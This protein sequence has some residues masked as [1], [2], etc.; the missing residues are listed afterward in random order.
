LSVQ[1]NAQHLFEY[2]AEVYAIDLPVV[3]DV[4][5][6]SNERWW[7]GSLIP[8]DNCRFRT[9]DYPASCA[10]SEDQ[11]GAW[12]SIT[13]CY[14]DP[15]PSLP[16]SLLHWVDLSP[17]P[18]ITPEPKVVRTKQ[19]RF[20][21]DTVRVASYEAYCDA[22]NKWNDQKEG[23][24]PLPETNLKSW[25]DTSCPKDSP[26]RPI[27]TREIE[28]RFDKDASRPEAF[29]N[30]LNDQWSLWSNRKKGP[31]R[32]N[33]LYDE[34]FS[35]HQRLSV[36]GDR[37]EILWGHL[38]LSWQHSPGHHIY[39]P[40]LLTPLFIDFDAQNRTITLTPSQT[41]RL[42]FECL[43]DLEYNFK[44]TL[45][46]LLRKI[47]EDEEP[48]N[49]WNHNTV[50][51]LAS[52]ISGY[53]SNRPQSE[54]N[55]YGDDA[56]IGPA[57]SNNHPSFSNSPIIFVRERVRHFWI[58]DAKNVAAAIASGTSVPPFIHAAVYNPDRDAPAQFAWADTNDPGQVRK[59]ESDD[60]L[61][62]PLHH[63]E[64]QKEIWD[65]L[66]SQFGVL[67]QGPPGTGKSHTIANI[68]CDYLARGK[69]IL[70]TSQTENSL[71]VL[72][73]HIPDGI[74]SLC[75][76]QLGNDTSAKT[77]LHEAVTTIGQHLS[78]KGSNAPAK[79]IESL[80]AALKQ[81]RRDQAQTASAIRE[82][83]KLDIETITIGGETITAYE[84]A[85]EVA[86][87]SKVSDWLPDKV[88]PTDEPPL[89]QTELS[90]LCTLAHTTAHQ[91]RKA[92][93]KKLPDLEKLPSPESIGD[94]LS[95][96]KT[97][98]SLAAETEFQRA[99]WT[100]QLFSA[101]E[102]QIAVAI[103][104]V[105]LA[106]KT[107]SA[108]QEKWQ[109]RMLELI[110]QE[111][112]QLLFWSNFIEAC[113]E[114]RHSAFKFFDRIQG[115]QIEGLATLDKAVEWIPAIDQLAKAVQKGK[116]PAGFFT[117][118]TLSKEAKLLYQSVSIDNKPLSTIER[119]D[120]ATD[121]LE[122]TESLERLEKRWE[123]SI[124]NIDGPQKNPTALMPLAD[125]DARLRLS[126]NPIEWYTSHYNKIRDTL[127]A[128]GCPTPGHNFHQEAVLTLHLH[129]LIGHKAF[130]D[131]NSITAELSSIV[132]TITRLS[133]NSNCHEQMTQL[134]D[135]IQCRS[136]SAYEQG[137]R[138]LERLHAVSSTV[139]SLEKLIGRLRSKA[140]LWCAQIEESA[141]KRGQDAIPVDWE[142]AWKCQ[143]LNQWLDKLHQRKNIS[144]LQTDAEKLRRRESE[145]LKELVIERTWQRQIE[146]VN[147]KHYTALA[148]WAQAMKNYGRG[149][150]PH[151][152][153]FLAAATK[154][155]IDAVK[156]VPVWI[157]PLYR[158]V[159]AF[160][161]QAGLFDLIIVDEASQCDIRAL[162]V[163]FRAKQVL[164]VGD[165]EQISPSNVGVPR[166]KIFEL[167]RLRLAEIPHP[168]RF[169]VDNS[170]F[171]VTQTIP[172]MTR[173]MLT[174]HFRCVSEIIEF[175]N[176]LCP[177]YGGQLEPLRQTNPHDRLVPPVVSYYVSDG[178]KSESDV[179]EAEAIALVE[180][181]K[182]CCSCDRY[183][184]K[185]MGIISLLGEQQAK[186][187]SNLLSKTI[188]EVERSKRRIVCGNAYAFQGDERDVMFLSLVVAR[189]ARFAALVKDDARQRF[190][191]ATSRARDQVFLFHSVS[192]EDIN[193]DNC[194]RHKLLKW[195]Q[196][197][198]L[199]EM[200]ANISTLREKAE[201][202]F[203]LEVGSL[204]IRNGFKVIPQY[205]PFLRDTSYRIDLLAQG[206][207]GKVAVECDGDRWHGPEQW[208]YD[209]K[210]EAQL[211]RAGL[212]FWRINGSTFYRNKDK[213][214]SE[215]WPILHRH[216]NGEG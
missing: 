96:L 152:Q 160:P 100:V 185:T 125:V 70:V 127:L 200:E 15:P 123:Q 150:G 94:L 79:R 33:Q 215:L 114:L 162:P 184:A 82:W 71:R 22:W 137:F 102:H 111:E 151:A 44:E 216:C 188:D 30:Y 47:N 155:M 91:D 49:P 201:S 146:K 183:S 205:R 165:P 88:N 53:L 46:S 202:P 16:E 64:Q 148:A 34:L 173:T 13:K 89:N 113:T 93:E 128:L 12:L 95:R 174:E 3:R 204:I 77:E 144:D 124:R 69:K 87:L 118:L 161:A 106:Q 119:I 39:H 75:V 176:T 90:E 108:M 84:A 76:S 180:A 29:K 196:N 85:Q 186:F 67:V 156:A 206:P 129:S 62:F 61:Y 60:E 6:Y 105:E 177:S 42:D 117:N 37:W 193:N 68:I 115:H 36:E 7:Q 107:L 179:N 72:R 97:A 158:V 142:L 63:N 56:T 48:P 181:V 104:T 134:C 40:L 194:M 59:A 138:E 133:E 198:P 110:A 4:L 86:L 98:Q 145:L 5:H 135:A 58:E 17:S 116:N 195:Y 103:E 11:V 131:V 139:A 147:D 157:M 178:V 9:Y 50:R 210:R 164:I 130:I 32:A 92:C 159:Q 141:T 197:P 190:N 120:I 26:P 154:A 21:E 81:N 99:E 170:L 207:R 136:Q 83:A 169:V 52:T 23:E 187:I 73:G 208:E 212:V 182:L 66:K 65:R 191:V 1:R 153:R 78:E 101:S 126:R 74:R 214:L 14:I 35:L 20:D 45:L 80:L 2:V 57:R 171:A 18:L 199:A 19:Q 55:L 189:N 27:T 122:Y 24:A 211:R 25:L 213:A 209:Q 172:G 143:R 51:G 132:R 149:T 140:P 121:Y 28:E 192:L 41:T 175:N 112:S 166:E 167:I 38:F 54:T 203:E 10:Q 43:R 163:L 109:Q 8:S 31:F 168:I